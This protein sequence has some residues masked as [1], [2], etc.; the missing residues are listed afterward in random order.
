MSLKGPI[1]AIKNVADGRR[2][3]FL[4][5]FP[6]TEC[7]I[8][9]FTEDLVNAVGRAPLGPQ[10]QVI[11]IN[12]DGKQQEYERRVVYQIEQEK[13]EDYYGLADYVNESDIDVLCVQHEFGIYGGDTGHHLVPL[14][15]ALR[16]PVVATMHTL[17]PRPPEAMRV[18]TQELVRRS[19][20]LVVMNAGAGHMLAEQYGADPARIRLIHHGTPD[21]GSRSPDRV[22][23]RLGLDGRTIIATFGLI[24]RSKGLEYAVE[25]M[26][27]I[28]ERHPDALYLILGQTHP[29]V[30][31]FEG[32]VYREALEAAIENWNL[33]DHVRFVNHYLTKEQLIDYLVATDIYLTP[34]LARNQIC[35]GALAYAVGAGKAIVSTPYWYALDILRGG[36]GMIVD[37]RD[38]RG[39]ADAC[40]LLLDSPEL[41]R[42][43]AART[44]LLGRRM[45]WRHVAREYAAVFQEAIAAAE[46][47]RVERVAP[48]QQPIGAVAA[49]GKK[50]A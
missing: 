15:G 35:S 11:A 12:V 20:V 42:T 43:L 24:S 6:P 3:A 39:I 37:F 49:V 38:P 40:G 5:T 44:R 25:A 14:L 22:K 47:R 26:A 10:T 31:R 28:A 8:A 27:S 16:K 33:Q 2:V 18:V 30:R 7:G 48:R 1:D 32:E 41:R 34:Y 13:L 23:R 46:T 19:D 9:T 21:F 45:L 4:S 17:L 50:S 36:R 29:V